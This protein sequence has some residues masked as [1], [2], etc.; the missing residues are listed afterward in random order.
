[1]KWWIIG[2]CSGDYMGILA[3]FSDEFSAHKRR[4]ELAAQYPAAR[5]AVEY[6]DD[7]QYLEDSFRRIM[8]T[9]GFDFVADVVDHE[10]TLEEIRRTASADHFEF[11]SRVKDRTQLT[12]LPD[13]PGY[14][15][16]LRFLDNIINHD[17]GLIEELESGFASESADAFAVGDYENLLGDVYFRRNY[18]QLRGRLQSV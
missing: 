6:S 1:M 16:Y 18:L 4:R 5:L 2:Y 8:Q 17:W 14:T 15:N 13:D 3:S 10:Q 7:K 9:A 12:A 11:I